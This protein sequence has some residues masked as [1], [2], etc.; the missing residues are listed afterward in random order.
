MKRTI[1]L[2]LVALMMAMLA[3]IPVSASTKT[4]HPSAHTVLVDGQAVA[5]RAFLIDGSNFFMLRDIA[6]V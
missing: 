2:L 5:F 4:A 3:V 1:K 6:Y